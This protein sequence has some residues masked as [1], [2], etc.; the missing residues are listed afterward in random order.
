MTLGVSFAFEE[1][2]TSLVQKARLSHEQCYRSQMYSKAFE[3]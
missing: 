1:D 3:K 2:V